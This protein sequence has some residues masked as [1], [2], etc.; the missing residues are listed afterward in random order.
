MKLTPANNVEQIWERLETLE[1]LD[2]QCADHRVDNKGF[3]E[4]TKKCILHQILLEGLNNYVFVTGTK[5]HRRQGKLRGHQGRDRGLPQ[6]R[7]RQYG[8][9][10]Q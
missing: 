8:P 6:G 9:D 3:D 10:G 1:D 2:R 5:H 7:T 4:L